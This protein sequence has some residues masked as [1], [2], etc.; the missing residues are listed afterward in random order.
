MAASLFMFWDVSGRLVEG[1]DWLSE[2]L[3]MADAS[4]PALVRAKALYALAHVTSG[5]LDADARAEPLLEESLALCRGLDARQEVLAT[6]RLAAVARLREDDTR[7]SALCTQ[8]LALAERVRDRVGTYLALSQLA[9]IAIQQGEFA[10]ARELGERSLLLKR[11]QGDEQAIGVSQ[12]TLAELAWLSGDAKRAADRLRESLMMHNHVRNR[13]GIADGL[14]LLAEISGARGESE[15]AVRLYGAVD[16]LRQATGARRTGVPRMDPARREATVALAR[17][18]L[19]AAE[20]ERAWSDGRQ[21][22]LDETMRYALAS[23]DESGQSR[24]QTLSTVITR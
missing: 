3:D 7:A 22:S 4:V 12:R 24:G 6:L 10:G 11:H 8:T 16:A 17:A 19:S 5:H 15:R 1:R 14:E 18:R 21:M 20:F 23:L 13:R 9:M 2:L